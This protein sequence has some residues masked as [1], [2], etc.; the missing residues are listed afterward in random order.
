[1]EKQHVTFRLLVNTLPFFFSSYTDKDGF[2]KEILTNQ[3]DTRG[4]LKKLKVTFNDYTLTVSTK[5]KK[6]IEF[7]KNSPFC[8]GSDNLIGR[9]LMKVVDA[10]ADKKKIVEEKTIIAKAMAIAYNLK[11]EEL[12]VY[13]VLCGTTSDDPIFQKEKVYSYAEINPVGFIELVGESNEF[14]SRITAFVR[15]ALN[16]KVI[17]KKGGIHMWED[18]ILGN[19]E[20]DAVA[21][22]SKDTEVYD[23]IQE[24][25][26]KAAVG[27]EKV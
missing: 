1:M 16:R 15:R 12:Q 8:E 7:I 11:D 24:A 18:V 2:V 23:A 3:K 27:S 19:S 22:L 26:R 20:D 21:Y 5:Q 6:L 9:P 4:N 25:F 10:R 17:T 14:I 13:A